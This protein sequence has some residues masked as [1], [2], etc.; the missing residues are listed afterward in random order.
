LIVITLE[1]SRWIAMGRVIF[2][3]QTSSTSI[4]VRYVHHQGKISTKHLTA[5]LRNLGEGEMM[6]NFCEQNRLMHTTET[7]K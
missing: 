4:G 5:L 7:P 1:V 6:S 3:T 2:F